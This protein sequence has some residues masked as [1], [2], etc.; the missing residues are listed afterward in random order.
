M[1]ADVRTKVGISATVQ[2]V[3][4]TLHGADIVA[5]GVASVAKKAFG[6]LKTG[7]AK[8]GKAIKNAC[9]CISNFTS[10]M[11][12]G[13]LKV[14]KA[15]GQLP[16]KIQEVIEAI[17]TRRQEKQAEAQRQDQ[18]KINGLPIAELQVVYDA[19][20]VKTISYGMGSQTIQESP[21]VRNAA[22]KELVRRLP[23]TGNTNLARISLDQ[24]LSTSVR[25]A[26]R[27]KLIEKIP[28]VTQ[29]NLMSLVKIANYK[30]QMAKF[31]DTELEQV[32]YGTQTTRTSLGCNGN[33]RYFM[34]DFEEKTTTYERSGLRAEAA[35]QMLREHSS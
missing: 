1:T 16:S 32:G 5:K 18:E 35:R 28:G 9:S 20:R 13:I 15:I 26:A 22:E 25:R 12:Q 33:G 31:T 24:G 6:A 21:D 8:A 10:K 4:V 11:L 17:R 2:A 29:K 14:F 34:E 30:Q 3:R 7:L 27:E 19:A 23:N